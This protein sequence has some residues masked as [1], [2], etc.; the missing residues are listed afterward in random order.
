MWKLKRFTFDIKT[1]VQNRNA[2]IE[3]SSNEQIQRIFVGRF[4][5]QVFSYV[6]SLPYDFE[7]LF[8][9]D[10]SFQGGRFEKV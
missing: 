8:N 3:L 1:T 7:Y 2:N 6:N 9:L 4:Y 10:N 5:Q